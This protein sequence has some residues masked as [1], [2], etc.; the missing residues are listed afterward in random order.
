MKLKVYYKESEK[1]G[2]ERKKR[3]ETVVLLIY[4]AKMK[5]LETRIIVNNLI[6][7]RMLI[8]HVAFL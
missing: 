6:I 7:S 2:E 3:E 1:Q 4:R 8:S 5:T